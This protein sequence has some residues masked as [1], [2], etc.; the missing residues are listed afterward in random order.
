MAVDLEWNNLCVVYIYSVLINITVI[1]LI[2]K[3]LGESLRSWRAQYIPFQE[4][5][6]QTGQIMVDTVMRCFPSPLPF[7]HVN[8]SLG[9]TSHRKTVWQVLSTS[10]FWLL[11]GSKHQAGQVAALNPASPVPVQVA[12]ASEA[13]GEGRVHL[14]FRRRRKIRYLQKESWKD[15]PWC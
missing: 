2:I 8:M 11:Q 7:P 5:K 13:P 14:R 9:D 12:L 4:L 3:Y 6:G 10:L 15:F 1:W